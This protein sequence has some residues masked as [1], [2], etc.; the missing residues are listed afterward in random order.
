MKGALKTERFAEMVR[1]FKPGA[2][3]V[4]KERLERG[5]AVFSV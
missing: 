3:G 4:T 1:F 5:T 2:G